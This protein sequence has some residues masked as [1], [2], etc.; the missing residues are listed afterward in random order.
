MKSLQSVPLEFSSFVTEAHK[1]ER[2]SIT[3]SR[4]RKKHATKSSIDP[5]PIPS[6]LRIILK[7][8]NELYP[9]IPYGSCSRIMTYTAVSTEEKA[10]RPWLYFLDDACIRSQRTRERADLYV[11]RSLIHSHGL[12]TASPIAANKPVIEYVGEIIPS[13]LADSRE[14][15]AEL[16]LQLLRPSINSA[17]SHVSSYFF[18]LDEDWVIDATRY[19]NVSR[20]INHS[21]N[22][23]CYAR[24][25]NSHKH[26]P[27]NLPTSEQ[28]VFFSKRDIKANEEILYDYQFPMEVDEG[29]RVA[30]KC[31]ASN[32]K[33]FLN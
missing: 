11:R 25:I 27:S 33:G 8:P 29:K 32:C 31:G 2:A 16:K 1:A 22:P 26:P 14:Q 21:C 28:I 24:V 23:N 10:R 19:G 7:L 4:G 17:A 30:C 6:T 20:F 15:A 18:R 5:V 13:S 9:I 12:F 3:G